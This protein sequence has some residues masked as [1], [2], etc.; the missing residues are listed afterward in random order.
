M[1]KLTINR[2]VLLSAIIAAI[3]GYLAVWFLG[4]LPDRTRI[5]WME[6]N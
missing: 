4:C 2:Q 6:W 5:W 1:K 3:G